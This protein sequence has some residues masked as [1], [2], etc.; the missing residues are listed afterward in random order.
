MEKML[1]EAK[2]MNILLKN[3]LE[4]EQKLWEERDER[5]RAENDNLRQ[6]LLNAL[7]QI[8]NGGG[9]NLH[10]L[11]SA[12]L[13]TSQPAARLPP[14]M[15]RSENVHDKETSPPWAQELRA[16]IE[17]VEHID[18]LSEDINYQESYSG[19]KA[20][21][22]NGPSSESVL[23]D[24]DLG[25]DQMAPP[26]GP[27]PELT[28]GADDIYWVNQLHNGLIDAGY[29]PGDE[30]IEDFYFGEATLSALQTMQACLGL[31]ESG[32]VDE[33]VWARLL[34]PD[35]QPRQNNSASQEELTVKEE[36]AVEQTTNFSIPPDNVEET[37]HHVRDSY[38][39]Q[40]SEVQHSKQ[41]DVRLSYEYHSE[42]HEETDLSMKV[43]WPV[44]MEGDGG[45]KVHSLHVALQD[46]GFAADEDEVRWW[47]FGDTTL[48][49]VKTFQA[50]CGIPES[51]I[52]DDRT[53]KSLLGADSKPED[54]FT[55]HSGLSDDE[56]LA[57][58]GGA[59]NGRGV[60]LIGE[61]RW[62]D[63]SK[64]HRQDP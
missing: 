27:P 26:S 40:K 22:T 59:A 18:V 60:W 42:I 31:P 38:S 14:E 15:S 28:I 16:A 41:G 43:S 20:V 52:C 51:G 8:N 54:V 36:G 5:L 35:L 2:E 33:R 11:K 47:H 23:G 63:R 21:N 34:G 19:M 44:L 29:Y 58:G 62:E 45:K 9:G 46:A 12:Y 30:D 1:Q 53:W 48:N 25:N 56:D 50:C 6:Q 55:L 64:L 61:Q 10:D 39:T 57:D 49:A 3:Q 17:A 13:P 24:I 37:A 32:V 4:T 7:S